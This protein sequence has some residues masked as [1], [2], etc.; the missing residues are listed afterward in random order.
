MRTEDFPAGLSL[1]RINESGHF[2]HQ[3]QHEAVNCSLI[4]FLNNPR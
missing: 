4:D 1:Q 2:L 3:E